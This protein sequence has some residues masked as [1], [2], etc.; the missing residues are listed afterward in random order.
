MGKAQALRIAVEHTANA[1]L[2]VTLAPRCAACARVLDAPLR[3]PVCERCWSDV[4]Q[5][6]APLCRTCGDPL[7]SWRVLSVALAQCP[8]CR[9]RPGAVDAGR[10]AGDY[11]GALRA[12]IHALKYDG[13]RSL[14]R[15]LGTMLR[16]AAPDLLHDADCL[17][18][19][20]L[21]PWRR[22]RRGFNQAAEIARQLEAPMVHAL[23]R[24]RATPPQTGLT[25]AARVRNVRGAFTV[26]PLL[27]RVRRRRLIDGRIVVLVDDVRTTGATLN[28]CARVLKQAGAREV[29]A[30][31]VAR[32]A[33][34]AR[35]A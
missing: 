25:A 27:S 3:G 4:R 14:A 8:R 33:P 6:A 30:L 32:A 7:P 15:P 9:R 28:E 29:R 31:T 17:V 19:V 16:S 35:R 24:R 26:S 20:P 22:L 21:H 23:W 2:T 13:R 34:P 5:L 12:I 18:P 11:E 10:A 1:V